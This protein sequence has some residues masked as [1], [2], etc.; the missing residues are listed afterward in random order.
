MKRLAE[1]AVAAEGCFGAQACSSDQ[2]PDFLV[3]VSR[4]KS[5]AALQAF[6]GAA[7]SLAEREHL[8]ALLDRP[9]QHEHLVPL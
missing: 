7:A 3:A 5:V 8:T 9:T 6:A 4:W 2:E 1:G